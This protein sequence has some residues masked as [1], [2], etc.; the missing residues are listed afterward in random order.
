MTLTHR[1]LRQ[2]VHAVLFVAGPDR[3]LLG[4]RFAV[5]VVVGQGFHRT[6]PLPNPRLH[7]VL[8]NGQIQV[9]SLE[10]GSGIIYAF[11]SRP[12]A[13]RLCARGSGVIS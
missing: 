4:G 5:Q 10:E 11:Q 3:G 6:H 12:E 2:T 13:G 8:V 9:L 7:L 1:E